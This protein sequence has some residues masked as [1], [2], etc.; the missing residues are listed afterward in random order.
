MS[1]YNYYQSL[2]RRY[3]EF[4]TFVFEE[5]YSRRSHF[6]DYLNQSEKESIFILLSGNKSEIYGDG[7]NLIKSPSGVFTNKEPLTNKRPLVG[8]SE[9]RFSEF[10]SREYYN[11]VENEYRGIIENKFQKKIMEE[12][13]RFDNMDILQSN[14]IKEIVCY[15]LDLERL[16]FND[17]LRRI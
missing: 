16:K 1:D 2:S 12:L 13:F 14:L 8:F 4:L 11:A 6:Y 5:V 10:I 15:I 9:Q 17:I 7:D 3:N